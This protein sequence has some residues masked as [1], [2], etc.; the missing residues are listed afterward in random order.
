MGTA[1]HGGIGNQRSFNI[2]GIEYRGTYRQLPGIC[3]KIISCG[4]QGELGQR[5]QFIGDLP[6][7]RCKFWRHGWP[8]RRLGRGGLARVRDDIANEHCNRSKHHQGADNFIGGSE[9]VFGV[10]VFVVYGIGHNCSLP[11]CG[12]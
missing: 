8:Q 2:R 11:M 5:S 12:N 9:R 6:T 10:V 7:W 4:L 1:H 3:A